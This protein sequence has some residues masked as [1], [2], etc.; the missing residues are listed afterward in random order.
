M[1]LTSNDTET[2][3]LL[4]PAATAVMSKLVNVSPAIALSNTGA[5]LVVELVLNCVL[6]LAIDIL[7]ATTFKRADAV[8]YPVPL[9]ITSIDDNVPSEPKYAFAVACVLFL[10][11]VAG[12]AISIVGT[13][14]YKCSVEIISMFSI[15]PVVS[16]G[17]ANVI[18]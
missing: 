1:L 18:N 3:A 9:Y 5:V 8:V 7:P 10:S 17:K 4:A 16:S 14:W 2:F 15:V 13:S 12:I 6:T 11:A